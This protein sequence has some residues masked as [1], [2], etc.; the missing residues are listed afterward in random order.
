MNWLL[1]R[2][3]RAAEFD[4]LSTLVTRIP[5]RLVVPHSDPAKIAVLCDLI[6]ADAQSHQDSTPFVSSP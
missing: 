1:D 5:V 3:Q 4:F 6:V 2:R